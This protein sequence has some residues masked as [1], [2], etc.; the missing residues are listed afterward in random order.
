M[1]NKDH[2][3]TKVSRSCKNCKYKYLKN[4]IK[5]GYCPYCSRNYKDMWEWYYAYLEESK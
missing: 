4:K 1:Q 3:E 2:R 5:N